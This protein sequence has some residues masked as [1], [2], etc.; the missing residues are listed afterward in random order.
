MRVWRL[1]V[2]LLLAGMAAACGGNSTTVGVTVSAPGI[3][4]GATATVITNGTLQFAA[5]VTGASASTVFWRICLPAA[6]PSIQPTNCTAVPAT[7]SNLGTVP[8]T[9]GSGLTGYGTISQTGLYTAPPAPPNPNSFVVMAI[10][11]ISPY[12]N[13]TGQSVNAYFGIAN[14]EID[15]GVR[16]QVVPSTATISAGSTQQ[17]TA[18]VTGTTNTGVSWQVNGIAG[19]NSSTGFICPNPLAPQPCTAGEYFAPTTA[20]TGSVTITAT[21]AADSTKS[22]TATVTISAISDVVL[23]TIDPITT[24]QSSAQ[25]DVYLT[26]SNFFTTDQVFVAAPGQATSAVTTT[27]IS[28]TLLR[29]TIPGSLLSAAGQVQISVLRQNGSPNSPGPLALNVTPM[30]PSIVASS[31]DSVSQNPNA[32]P[33]VT[34]T[35]GYFSPSATTALFNGTSIA[36]SIASSRSL[37]LAIP[38]GALAT[39]GLYPIVVQNSGLAAG[40]PMMSALNLG[41][42]P[43]TATIPGAPKATVAVGSSPSA[44]AIDYATGTAVVANQGSNTV[45]L[46]N[47]NANPPAVKATIAVGNAPTGVAID[48]LLAHHIAVV[49]N[50]GDQTLS[51][52][53]LTTGAV[54][55]TVSV[56][57]GPTAGSPAGPS[58]VPFSVGINS[59]THHGVVAYESFNEATILDVSTGTP[60]ILQQIG[61]DPTAPIGTGT[62]PGI[63][64]D[65][66]LDWA[67]VTPGGG[68]AQTT[69]VVDLGQ[70]AGG[71]DVARVPQVIASLALAASGVGINSETHQA[72]L[73]APNAGNLATFSL[74]DNSVNTITFQSN[75]VTLSQL[76]FVAA[77]VDSLENLGIAVNTVSSTATIVDLESGNVLQTVS[78][79]GSTPIA[80]GVDPATNQA[81]VVNQGSNSVSVLSLS[82]AV[83]PLQIVEASPA[84]AF[85]SSSPLTL[86]VTGEGFTSSSVVRLDQVPL[87][88]TAVTSTCSG[89]PSTCRQLTATVPASMLAGAR[90]YA[91]DVLNSGSVSN[92]IAL[93]VVQAITVGNAPVGVAVDTDRDLAVVTNSG[94]GTVSLVALTASTPVGINQTPAGAVGTIGAPLSVGTS[95]LGVAVLPRLGL[96]LV[97]NNGSNNASLV[98]VTQTYVPQTESICAG[99]G[100]CTGPTAVAINPDTGGA[101]VTN[102]GI[103]NDT[104]APSSISI[105]VISPA[106][107]ST[108]PSF[109]AS[110]I[111]SNV[112]QNPVA[113]AIDPRPYP[114]NP[115]VSLA[116][117]GTSSQTSSVEVIDLSTDIPQRISGLQN[118]SGIIF[119]PLNQV[120]VIANTLNNNLILLDPVA[121]VQTSVRV[122]IDPTAL[123]YDYQNSTLMTSNYTSHTLSVL[124]YVCPPSSSGTTC[125][126][127]QVRAVLNLGGSQQFSVAMD[128]KLNL[129][130]VADQT[131]NRVLLVPLP[132]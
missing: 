131:N 99:G 46:I 37:S 115:A 7:A 107:T 8:T 5:T 53:D 88:T 123:D 118:P 31:P 102:A 20:P 23:T 58:P 76:G 59:L 38:P 52:I 105:G 100:S 80:V 106:T 11:T 4:T 66:R 48:D 93:T 117:V 85:T 95:P 22:G 70:N 128:P 45:S 51:T 89:S 13:E 29:A 15:S 86:A 10:S 21:S 42:T 126:N 26:G 114:T 56:A 111:A 17:F 63:F 27:Y 36:P 122:G 116:A 82:A 25:Q 67:L 28:A 60:V 87:T 41:V 49:V 30:R 124:D 125:L 112:D 2:V 18:T 1:G 62:T 83:D 84:V 69:T 24:S 81:L 129:A 90:N 110:S 14:V 130:V 68:G 40:Q 74:L 64:V 12:L 103:L 16:V 54:T 132:H 91:V 109:V 44:I 71:G 119:D 127:P 108:A 79:L 39:P 75:G 113:V 92:V 78:G 77:G 34:L 33:T 32:S 121:L 6:Q 50:S 101:I 73:T 120:F 94:S 72:L 43:T 104:A 61:G 35:G 9:T 55:S 98:D 19:G 96:A 3:T 47:L 57:I 97:A 65:E